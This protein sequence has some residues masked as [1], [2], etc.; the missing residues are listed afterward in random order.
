MPLCPFNDRECTSQC[1][2]YDESREEKCLI[3]HRL[4]RTNMLLNFMEKRSRE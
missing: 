3:L 4:D 2:A 1:M